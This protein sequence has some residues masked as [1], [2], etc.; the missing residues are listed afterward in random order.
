MPYPSKTDRHAILAAA[1]QQLAHHG[2]RDMS[3]RQLA[4]TLGLAPNA[5]YRYF[6]DRA[7]LEQALTTE[8]ARQLH[9][10]LSRAAGTRP[11]AEAI[12]HMAF[13]Y[14][15]FAREHRH[16]YEMLLLPG[17]PLEEG[18]VAVHEQLWAFVVDRVA[19]VVSAA[20][21][22]EA[23]VALWAFLHGMAVLEAARVFGKEKP[24]SGFEFGLNAWLA[25]ASDAATIKNR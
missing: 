13:A 23:A 9:M 2:V 20:R 7:A 17:T 12:R 24:F 16:L 6:A 25:T 4:V 1:I 5:L 10:A 18:D 21:A 19:R 3:L 8:S 11:P 15:R 14:L 22:G